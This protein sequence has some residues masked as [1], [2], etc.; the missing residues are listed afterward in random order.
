M[1][2][3]KIFIRKKIIGKLCYAVRVSLGVRNIDAVVI[4]PLGFFIRWT[5]P[6]CI[7]YKHFTKLLEDAVAANPISEENLKKIEAHMEQIAVLAASCNLTKEELK[8]MLDFC[9]EDKT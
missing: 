5:F 7:N 9:M 4:S 6:T 8:A 1:I 2:E 3:I